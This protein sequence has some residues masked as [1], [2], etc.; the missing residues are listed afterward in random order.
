MP[1]SATGAGPRIF[2]P[3]DWAAAFR[4]SGS[5]PRP[6]S[7]GG[8]PNRENGGEREGEPLRSFWY[9]CCLPSAPDTT[10]RMRKGQSVGH[11]DW[12]LRWR[13]GE[14]YL[15]VR[16]IAVLCVDTSAHRLAGKAEELT[17]TRGFVSQDFPSHILPVLQRNQLSTLLISM[18]LGPLP[19]HRAGIQNTSAT[20]KLSSISHTT[21]ITR[22]RPRKKQTYHTP[23]IYTDLTGQAHTI[24][25]ALPGTSTAAQPPS[26]PPKTRTGCS[27]PPHPRQGEPS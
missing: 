9:S 24:R 20:L 1:G 16:A 3:F 7:L 25:Y 10:P 6:C 17:C 18:T 2:L 8:G 5:S 27:A 19:T 13:T 22:R 26:S 11:R 12:F 21:T 14:K 15:S 4:A 23:Y